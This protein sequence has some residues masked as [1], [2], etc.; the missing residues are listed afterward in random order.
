MR[1]EAAGYDTDATELI[2]PENTPKNLMLRGYK[3]KSFSPS[4]RERAEKSYKD[5]YRFMYGYS[6]APLSEVNIN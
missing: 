6:P 2:D 5:A 3:K 1:L 4:A